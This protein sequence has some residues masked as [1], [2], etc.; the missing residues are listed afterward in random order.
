MSDESASQ[1]LLSA[2]EIA[3]RLPGPWQDEKDGY[4]YPHPQRRITIR[5]QTNLSWEILQYTERDPFADSDRFARELLELIGDDLS[6]NDTMALIRALA[7][8]LSAWQIRRSGTN[9]DDPIR[10]CF[11]EALKAHQA[12]QAAAAPG[13]PAAEPA[14]RLEPTSA[15]PAAAY[16]PGDPVR[17]LGVDT[18]VESIEIL[19]TLRGGT[20]ASERLLEPI[21]QKEV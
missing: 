12:A 5:V 2:R 17:Y 16:R 13:T 4:A 8:Q 19:Y 15:P 18:R 6:A 1:G 14:R 20:R 7:S 11:D 9:G 10:E 21:P 3:E